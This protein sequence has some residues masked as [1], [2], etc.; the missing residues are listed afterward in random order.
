MARPRDPHRRTEILDAVLDHLAEHGMSGLSMRPIAQALGQSTRVLTHHFAD[1][2][3]LLAALLQRLD[4]VQHEQLRATE[5]WDDLGRG[6]GAIVR[7]SWYRHLAPEN[8]AHTR[9]VREIE[10]LAAAGRLGDRVPKFLT[11]R[12]EFVA[13]ALVAR[14]LDPAQARV[15][16][17][18]LNGAYSGLQTDILTTGDRERVETALDELCLLADSW[19]ENAARTV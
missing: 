10:G 2:D 7:D 9:L 15:K 13:R 17:T 8:V 14:G 16:A 1:K 6:I 11:D 5:G 4:D 3:D 19:T 18:Y 12:A